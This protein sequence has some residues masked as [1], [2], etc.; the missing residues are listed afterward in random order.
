MKRSTKLLLSTVS[1]FLLTIMIIGL[2]YG[3]SDK[4]KQAATESETHVVEQSKSD[5]LTKPERT[6]VETNAD[7]LPESNKTEQD[8]RASITSKEENPPAQ[9][10]TSASNQKSTDTKNTT[11]SEK[12]APSSQQTTS[13][14]VNSQPKE[15]AEQKQDQTGQSEKPKETSDKQTPAVS[16]VTYS[17]VADKDTGTIIPAA[18]VEIKE[19]DT[20]LDILIKI[21]KEKKVPM[22]FRGGTGATAYV[23]GINNL[24][25]FDKGQ[26]SGWMYRVNGIF[27]NKSAGAVPLLN[28]DRIE[29]LYTLDL[30]KDIGAELQPFR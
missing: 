13:S 20:V 30:G 9:N 14:N 12:Q 16:K 29:W 21:T 22:S 24:F 6:K 8:E 5:K 23:E 17:I 19:G 11:S 2:V 15:N 27:P 10:S 3:F 18:T 7:A 25:E 26:G 4:N 1:I 28:G